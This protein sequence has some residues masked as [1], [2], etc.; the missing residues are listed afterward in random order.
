[1]AYEQLSALDAAFSYLERNG[2]L[3]VGALAIVDGGELLDGD[4]QVRTAVISEH[5]AGRLH[6]VGR[7]RKK[8]VS[9]PFG[10]GHPV[11]VDD[12]DFDPANHIRAATVPEPGGDAQLNDLMAAIQA[13]PLDRTRPL[14]ELWVVAGLAGGRVAIIQ[15]THHSVLD[16]I[17]GVDAARALFDRD[18]DPPTPTGPVP[19]WAPQA[20]PTRTAL[21]G[22][23]LA[24]TAGQV[25]GVLAAAGSAVREPA[26]TAG[27]AVRL[28]RNGWAALAPAARCSL[29]VPVGPRRRFDTFS[30]DIGAVYATKRA[31]GCTANDLVLA[32]VA[33][34]L[35][36]YLMDRGEPVEGR[37]LRAMVPVSIRRRSE[38]GTLGNR[39]SA[40]FADL[41]VHLA[42]PVERARAAHAE[43]AR[44]TRDRQAEDNDW[45]LTA[46]GHAPAPLYAA[47]AARLPAWQRSANL[48]VTHVPGP[49]RS[50]YC[51]GGR[52]TEAYPYVAPVH[53]MALGVAVLR[54]NHRLFFGLSTDPDALP[55]AASVAESTEKAAAELLNRP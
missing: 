8:P 19:E 55:E 26:R 4:G 29:N 16:G 27:T 35:R 45:F 21:L 36:H 37:T 39:I 11:L 50:L 53:G 23:A 5:L 48:V 7:F 25:T 14:W 49:V 42:D 18:P 34:G 24:T 44:L 41:P 40:V 13:E 52:L 9:V 1:M 2:P 46:A 38:R 20:P 33:G 28:A 54:Y 10:L 15:K 12:A 51:L 30:L 43:T 17:S 31:L 47:A 6:R 3:N 32:A 22:G